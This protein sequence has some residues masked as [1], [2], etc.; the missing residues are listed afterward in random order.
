MRTLL[1]L[2]K[3]L[4]EAAD[5]HARG[6]ELFNINLIRDLAELGWRVTVA[7]HPSWAARIRSRTDSENVEIVSIE[8]EGQGLFAS[9]RL[10]RALGRRA[11][12]ALILG[13]VANR[14]IPVMLLLRV[15]RAAP[16]CVLIAHR[17]PSRRCLWAQ[18]LWPSTVVAVNRQIASHFERRGFPRVSVYYGVTDAERYAPAA[19]RQADGCVH[20]CVA[21][22]LDNAWK[23]SD[24][25]VAAFR[26]LPENVGRNCRLHLASFRNP[27]DF[28]DNRIRAYAWMDAAAMPDFFRRMDAMIVPSRDEVVMRETFSQVM[29]QGMLS[30]LPM[31]VNRLPILEEKLDNGGGLVF[32][33]AQGLCDAMVRLANDAAERQRMGQAARA[34]AQARYAWNTKTFAEQ[35]LPSHKRL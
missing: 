17:E 11:F 33:D 25:A 7:A 21:G 13:N 8:Y 29:V 31:L 19:D 14:L 16:L 10:I 2:D 35:F 1:F 22:Q 24:T 34:T 32:D 4:L 30:G 12:S 28:G 18:K 27:P 15:C 9:W 20:F 3:V 23:G 5:E 26:M 6:V